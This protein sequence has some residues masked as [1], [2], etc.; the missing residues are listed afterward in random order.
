MRSI[1]AYYLFLLQILVMAR[2]LIPQIAD[3][4]FH[5]FALAIHIATVHARYGSN[6]V[7][8]ELENTADDNNKKNTTVKTEESPAVYIPAG[9][10]SCC[11]YEYRD[12]AYPLIHLRPIPAIFI[13]IQTPPPKFP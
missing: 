13:S 3:A 9:E 6:H 11:F 12:K 4:C 8:K 7:G 1:A 5:S 10:Y 2:P